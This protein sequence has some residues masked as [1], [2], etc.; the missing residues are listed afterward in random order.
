[1]MQDDHDLYTSLA[2]DSNMFFMTRNKDLMNP[3][4]KQA[5]KIQS[6]TVRELVK[7]SFQGKTHHLVEDI[8]GQIGS[9]NK[10]KRET[11]RS[12]KNVDSKLFDVKKNEVQCIDRVNHIKD[13]RTE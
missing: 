7:T 6:K 9:I 3:A 8:I 1:M 10:L 13:F 12:K 2:R 11:A 5:Q 4:A